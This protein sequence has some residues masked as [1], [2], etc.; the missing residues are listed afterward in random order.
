[1]EEERLRLG[2]R[3]PGRR[4]ITPGRTAGEGSGERKDGGRRR[5]RSDGK[6][7]NARV[8]SDSG[9]IGE[10]ERRWRA[11]HTGPS[12]LGTGNRLLAKFGIRRFFYPILTN[13]TEFY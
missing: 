12:G 4:R 8:G 7:R 2:D 11:G 3:R 10:R 1:V 6:Q 13:L 9:W 5:L